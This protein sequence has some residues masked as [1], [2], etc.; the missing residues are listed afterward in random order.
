MAPLQL[1]DVQT[2]PTATVRGIVTKA[3]DQH[4]CRIVVVGQRITEVESL[5]KIEDLKIGRITKL[6][7]GELK[8]AYY[9]AGGV[10][11]KSVPK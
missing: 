2:R 10:V 9:S 5:T 1:K 8:F 11:C 6:E 3:S 7:D 4:N